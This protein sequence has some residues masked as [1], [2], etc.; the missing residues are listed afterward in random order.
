VANPVF[1][2]EEKHHGGSVE[3]EIFCETEG[4][5]IYYTTNGN[6]P[7]QSDHLFEYSF[8]LY[9]GTHTLKAKAFKTGMLPSETVSATYYVGGSVSESKLDELISVYPNPTTGELR[10]TSDKLQIENIEVFDVYGRK[11]FSNH[12]I[13]SSSHQKINIENLSSGVYFMKLNTD[14]GE[15]IKRVIK[16]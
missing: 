3:V 2:P 11:I 7:T 1:Y 16:E 6:E 4:A 10:V 8:T 5:E 9:V 15:V 13:T 14:K 12:L